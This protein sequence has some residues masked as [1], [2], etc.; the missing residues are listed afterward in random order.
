M[1]TLKGMD[2]VLISVSVMVD[3]LKIRFKTKV[4]SCGQ[5]AIPD[6]TFLQ[7]CLSYVV[8]TTHMLQ[9]F[10]S[11]PRRIFPVCDIPIISVISL[12]ISSGPRVSVPCQLDQVPLLLI[13]NLSPIRIASTFS[14]YFVHVVEPGTGTSMCLSDFG[15]STAVY[16]GTC[17]CRYCQTQKWKHNMYS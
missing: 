7:A 1:K 14:C 17:R 4:F 13:Y 12:S 15:V 11:V 10:Q 6:V 2:K 5:A 8:N 16:A 9:R 3:K